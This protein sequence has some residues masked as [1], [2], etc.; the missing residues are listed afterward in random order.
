MEMDS[1]NQLNCSN[2]TNSTCERPKDHFGSFYSV[3]P[4]EQLITLWVLFVCVIGGNVLVLLATC[5]ARRRKPRMTFF[6]INLAVADILTGL[7]NILSNIIWRFTGEFL[8]SDL[9]C[10]LVKYFQVVLLYA[11]TYVLVSLSIDRYMAIVHPMKL[12]KGDRYSCCLIGLAW[13]LAFL[14]SAPTL[15]LFHK[16]QLGNGEMQCWSDWPDDTFW[17]P[18]MTLVAFLIYFCPLMIMCVVYFFVVRKIWM[19][20]KMTANNQRDQT[21]GRTVFLHRGSIPRARVKA[22]KYSLLI[23]LGQI[24]SGSILELVSTLL[25]PLPLYSTL[26]IVLRLNSSR[27]SQQ[28]HI[29]A[30]STCLAMMR[31]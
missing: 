2:G 26:W 16:K 10:R 28:C 5:S 8:A 7:V 19:K 27:N 14:F 4:M 25:L 29:F 31:C 11:S 9:V 12:F 3:Y 15:F 22:V 17:T 18:Y 6:V 21:G 13:A 30:S 24:S 23:V 1:S 20:S